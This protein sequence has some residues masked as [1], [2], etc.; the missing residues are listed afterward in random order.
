MRFDELFTG[1]VALL[2]GPVR[3]RLDGDFPLDWAVLEDAATGAELARAVDARRRL[4]QPV[5]GLVHRLIRDI[6]IVP[7]DV[8]RGVERAGMAGAWI[9]WVTMDAGGESYQLRND[10][11]GEVHADV[12]PEA[13]AGY[14]TLGMDLVTL[15]HETVERW[16]E[17]G[18]HHR[19]TAREARDLPGQCAV[20]MHEHL[21][22]RPETISGHRTAA[23]LAR[24]LEH[25]WNTQSFE[26]RAALSGLRFSTARGARAP[27]RSYL[28]PVTG[29]RLHA[30]DPGEVRWLRALAE[31]AVT[32]AGSGE[33]PPAPRETGGSVRRLGKAVEDT[34]RA[35]GSAGGSEADT[36]RTDPAGPALEL[37][38]SPEGLMP[39]TELAELERAAN[40]LSSS[41]PRRL[42]EVYGAGVAEAVGRLRSSREVGALRAVLDPPGPGRAAPAPPW[43]GEL[44][45]AMLMDAGA[46]TR[47][48]SRTAPMRLEQG[49]RPNHR[50]RATEVE[51]GAVGYL[52]SCELVE[53][54]RLGLG[55]AHDAGVGLAALRSVGKEGEWALNEAQS[56]TG[57]LS[58]QERETLE[59][60]RDIGQALGRVQR[61][62]GG[63]AGDRPPSALDQAAMAA[64]TLR[65]VGPAI[66]TAAGWP[67]A[68]PAPNPRMPQDVARIAAVAEG[69]HAE[70]RSIA[71]RLIAG[72]VAEAQAGGG[73]RSA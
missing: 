65:T 11:S 21:R 18:R 50:H 73:S 47:E 36:A 29:H 55:Y 56:G 4:P 7:D 54:I 27:R 51:S 32:S 30:C 17:A 2:P 22:A 67:G 24:T 23:T 5:E 31:R 41:V 3:E 64:E 8:A 14:A 20:R 33:A 66:R 60:A 69:L 63:A 52:T 9:D 26:V 71:D 45:A 68:A 48:G 57:R 61:S 1:A 72:Y 35:G 16:L 39:A 28:A 38:S 34:A 59:A 13:V 49:R 15:L 40:R 44:A 19:E 42:R 37:G 53:Q 25:A 58:E 6:G 10:R 43:F 62:S 46:Q 12:R 70:I